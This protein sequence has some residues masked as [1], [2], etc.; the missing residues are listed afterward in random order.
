MERTSEEKLQLELD[1]AR[2]RV[3]QLEQQNEKLR[4]KLAWVVSYG[5]LP[6]EPH[7]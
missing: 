5:P 2:S 1:Q 3:R 6:I 4:C 7:V